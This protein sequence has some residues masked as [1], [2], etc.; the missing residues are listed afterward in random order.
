MNKTLA[1]VLLAGVLA[2]PCRTLAA[3][4]SP[5][6]VDKLMGLLGLERIPNWVV[7]QMDQGMKAAM[8][9][10]VAGRHITSDEEKRLEDFRAQA[11]GKVRDQLSWPKL[12]GLYA[13]VYSD[14]LTQEEVDGLIGFYSTPVGQSYVGKQPQITRETG[15]IAQQQIGPLIMDTQLAMQNLMRQ[16]IA[17]HA[18]D[19]QAEPAAGAAA[20]PAAATAD[21]HAKGS[22]P[23][24]ISQGE[25]VD[26]KDYLVPGKTTVFDF[27]SRFCPPCMAL[28]PLLQKL[29]QQRDDVAVVKVDINRPGIKGIDWDSPVAG[30]FKLESIPHLT[31]YKPD[32]TLLADGDD[33]QNIVEGW[34][35]SLK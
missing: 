31:V 22:E 18:N 14:N 24:H 11:E 27:Y 1:V 23:L 33:A 10:A 32:G 25:K 17:A 6:S 15:L 26:L 21:T 20:E 8:D 5:E 30:E 16:I 19:G 7:A 29:H 3:P 4:P 28:S 13:K 2:I 34:L 35:A 12:K 9:G